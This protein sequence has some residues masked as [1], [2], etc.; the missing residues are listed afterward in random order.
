ML[1]PPATAGVY[2]NDAEDGLI[3]IEGGWTVLPEK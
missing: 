3:D 2:V 1:A